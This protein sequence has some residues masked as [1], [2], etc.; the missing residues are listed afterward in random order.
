MCVSLETCWTPSPSTTSFFRACSSSTFSRS[1]SSHFPGL[2]IANKCHN[3][4]FLL[5]LA[6]HLPTSACWDVVELSLGTCF[7]CH[8]YVGVS[9]SLIAL[10]YLC[11]TDSFYV[12]SWGPFPELSFYMFNCILAPAAR[13]GFL[14]KAVSPAIFSILING[15]SILPF[16][17]PKS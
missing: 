2:V 16:T 11:I 7:C 10:N 4:P 17:E 5:L 6:S 15:N 12:F 9:T 14:T 1:L 13:C 3:F 8:F